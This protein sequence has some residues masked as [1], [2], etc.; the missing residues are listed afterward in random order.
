LA[1]Q[2]GM[3]IAAVANQMDLMSPGHGGLTLMD[4]EDGLGIPMSKE[5]WNAYADVSARM[6]VLIPLPKISLNQLLSL[7]PG[8]RLVSLCQISQDVPLLVGDVFLANVSCE[9]AGERLGVRINGFDQP[10]K[11]L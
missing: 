8:T 6:S 4:A 1:E 7:K 2:V 9:P 3:A 11:G 10:L 5:R